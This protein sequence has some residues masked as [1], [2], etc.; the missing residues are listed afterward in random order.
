MGRLQTAKR[1]A[2]TLRHLRPVQLIG[3]VAGEGKRRLGLVKAP[4]VPEGFQPAGLTPRVPFPH[5]DPWNSADALRAGRFTFL[6]DTRDLGF[7]PDWAAEEAPLLWRFNLHYHHFLHLLAPE[8]AANLARHWAEHNP[9]DTPVAWHPYPT[10]LRLLVWTKADFGVLGTGTPGLAAS[11]YQQAGHL[12]RG[13]ETYHP[14][15]HLLENARALVLAGRWAGEQGE[16]PQWRQRGLDILLKET[17]D[18]VLPDGAYF[19]RS[20]MYHQLMLEA[21]LD[22]LNVHPVGEA[23][24]APLRDAAMRMAGHLEAIL[25]P[26]GSIPLFN[27]ATE[28][29]APPPAD[30]LA[31]ARAVLGET[32]PPRTAYPHAGVFVLQAPGAHVVCDAGPIGP[33]HLPAHAHADIFSFEASFGG[34]RF[35]TDTGVYEYAAGDERQHDRSTAAHNTVAVDGLSQAECWASF[36]VARRFPP[37]QV[38]YQEQ[39]D[40]RRLSGLFD[41]WG[42]LVGDEIAHRRTFELEPGSLAIEDHVTGKGQHQVEARVHLHPGVVVE[43]RGGGVFGLVRGD[44]EVEVRVEGVG[45]HVERS[46]YSPRFGV[47]VD[48]ACLVVGGAVALPVQFRCTFSYALP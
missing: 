25:H 24:L 23:A 9:P 11:L 6:D 36:R 5:H 22:V 45:A 14:G 13:L 48:R 2:E 38:S 46:R 26:D 34:V 30:T 33:D 29:I 12:Y 20:P 28:E 47:A 16:G 10:A 27:D 18:Q 39:D 21:Y 4:D 1:Y 19:E 37:Q 31:Y 7:P 3:R 17:P 43:E 40:G 32:T 42:T 44:V 41:G 8:E 15:N 35:V